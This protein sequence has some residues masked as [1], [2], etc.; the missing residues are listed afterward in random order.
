MNARLLEKKL[1]DF[2]VEGKVVEI[3]PGPVITMYE[4]EPASGVKINRITNLS[5]DLALAMKAQSVRIIAP[6]PGKAAIGI[7]IP[8]QER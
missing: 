6:I 5:D 3:K 1:A 4:L 7:E 2:G 8:N